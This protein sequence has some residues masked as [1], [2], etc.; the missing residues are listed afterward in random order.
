MS[1]T[2]NQY[3]DCPRCGYDLSGAIATWTD[4]CPV[5]GRCTECGL[6]FRWGEVIDPARR[7][8][9]WSFEHA[10]R[11]RLR[12]FIATLARLFVPRVFWGSM[13]MEFPFAPGRIVLLLLVWCVVLLLV[14]DTVTVVW[15]YFVLSSSWAWRSADPASYVFSLLWPRTILG[16]SELGYF[17]FGFIDRPVV[18]WWL[19][20]G[21]CLTPIAF[22]LLTQTLQQARVRRLHLLRIWA[23]G[24]PVLIVLGAMPWCCEDTYNGIVQ[25]SVGDTIIRSVGI[26]Q[27]RNEVT[28]HG[29]QLLMVAWFAWQWLW[30]WRACSLYLKLPNAKSIAA[31]LVLLGFLAAALPVVLCPWLS[32]P[33]VSDVFWWR[34]RI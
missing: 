32:T 2:T 27:L 7:V 29:W 20:L 31:L 13:R 1:G 33:W 17:T 34:G 23:Y 19:F 8:P 15:E 22:L 6:E 11:G 21:A 30:W 28:G 5:T 26:D 9:G 10:A 14:F 3:H 24:I 18:T 25:T 12:A 16:S 4:A